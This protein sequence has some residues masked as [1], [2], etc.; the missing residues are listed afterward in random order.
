M[1]SFITVSIASGVPDAFHDAVHRLVDHGH[2]DPVGHEARVVGDLDRRLADRARELHH[3]G[4]GRVARGEAADHLDELHDRDRVHE[5]HADHLLGAPGARRDL[6][7]GDRARVRREDRPVAGEAVEVGEDLELEV[8]VL[9]RGLDHERRVGRRAEVGA[10]R[11]AAERGVAGGAVEG[12]L[13]HLPL[14]VLLDGLAAA[15][16]R[17]VADVEHGHVEA[18]L[19]E[20]VGDAVPHLAGADDGDAARGG[21]GGRR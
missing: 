4:G 15:G 17:G 19:G 13:L 8:A 5:V 20:D 12:A 10:R 7:D 18:A 21:R 11:E 6:G 3:G 14:Q 2:Q 9:G 1:P 16:E